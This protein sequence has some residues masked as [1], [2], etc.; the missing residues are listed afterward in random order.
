MPFVSAHNLVLL[1]SLLT[2][3]VQSCPQ[4]AAQTS[5]PAVF[6][7]TLFAAGQHDVALYR[8]PGVA[9]TTRGTVLAWCEARRKSKSDWGEIE[10]HLRRST[11]QGRTWSEPLQIA[12]R[13]S[14]VAGTS[15]DA[16]ADAEQTVNNPVAII[17]RET[18][19]IEFLYCINYARCFSIRST[20]DGL[21]WSDP[22]EI[23]AAFEGFRSGC[24]WKVL[25]TGPGHGIQLRSGR[26]VVPVWLAYGGVRDH[27]PSVSA[28]IYSD[29]HGQTWQAGE[30]AV[31]DVGEFQDPNETTVTELSDGRVLL[32]SRN[33]SKSSRKLISTSPDGASAWTPP[34]FHA[35]LWEPICMASVAS[36]PGQPGWVVFSCPRT[37]ARDRQGREIPGGRGRR[38]NLSVLLSRDFGRTWP[39]QRTLEP[40]K[41]AYSD[42]AFLPDGR[43]LCFYE[44]DSSLQL[45][46][47]SLQWLEGKGEQR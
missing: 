39:V 36:V 4:A 11:D 31:P 42:L 41:S 8:I 12:H 7:T 20:D 9:V 37:L 33:E 22:R 14:R 3:L 44:A 2:V 45:A 24:D 23:T 17:D 27:H 30:I 35:D 18:Q 19:A 38:E 10:V 43:L 6:R 13:G 29:D 47:F 40:G 32:I 34:Q 46:V 21:T 1:V 15:G 28:T 16:A 26:L 25:A 5:E